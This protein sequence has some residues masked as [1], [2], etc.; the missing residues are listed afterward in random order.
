MFLCCDVV[1]LVCLQCCTL[2]V[3]M[4]VVMVGDWW[5]VVGVGDWWSVVGKRWLV[6]GGLWLALV[7]WWLV[8]FGRFR[9]F[10]RF[11]R[12]RRFGFFRRF[13]RSRSRH[14]RR[15]LRYYR[16][17][18]V[19]RLLSRVR[20]WRS[21]W[22]CS[23]DGGGGVCGMVCGGNAGVRTCVIYIEFC[24]YVLMW[25]GYVMLCYVMLC[26]HCDLLNR[27]MS[28]Y[29]DAGMGVCWRWTLQWFDA[30]MLCDMLYG[31]PIYVPML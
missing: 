13:R 27:A 12:F 18:V 25:L 11:C 9:R 7:G 22:W 6:F 24:F 30:V 26:W 10:P 17:S 1:M 31:G 29:C 21:W 3:V 2:G 15:F 5:L 23:G 4:M 16:R 14:L 20:L 8:V 28:L 19:R